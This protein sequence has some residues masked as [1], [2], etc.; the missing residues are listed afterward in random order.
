[1]ALARIVLMLWAACADASRSLN[2]DLLSS[3]TLQTKTAAMSD[4]DP[5]ASD[6]KKY[7]ALVKLSEAAKNKA[8]YWDTCPALRNGK[9]PSDCE[10][11]PAAIKLSFTQGAYRW[12]GRQ[13]SGACE[14]KCRYKDEYMLRPES[15]QGFFATSL[16]VMQDKIQRQ[17]AAGCSSLFLWHLP[18][19]A[20]RQ[21]KLLSLAKFVFSAFGRLKDQIASEADCEEKLPHELRRQL[22]AVWEELWSQFVDSA[23]AMEGQ[24]MPHI[25]FTEMSTVIHT[26][27]SSEFCKQMEQVV[28]NKQA[29]GNPADPPNVA[30]LAFETAKLAKASGRNVTEQELLQKA[31]DLLGSQTQE[32]FEQELNGD[33][34]A[35][36][37]A[38]SAPATGNNH[39]MSLV[40]LDGSAI[41]SRGIKD[42]IFLLFAKFVVRGVLGSIFGTLATA[43][44]WLSFGSY[45][46]DADAGVTD[47]HGW[48]TIGWIPLCV[49]QSFAHGWGFTD[50]VKITGVY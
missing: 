10:A 25:D 48:W 46:N 15:V 47:I 39:G 45:T 5:Q 26:I 40:Q 38:I 50:G 44:C 11:F 17:K 7:G 9:C 43:V 31:Q 21:K 24:G 42:A 14:K 2:E 37:K 27:G 36:E 12:L 23:S 13:W 22:S 6:A 35:L 20:A 29:S 16:A 32:N 30:Q 34:A 4:C 28:R 33:E 1:M 49:I 41:E 3:K 19:C 18:S 8:R